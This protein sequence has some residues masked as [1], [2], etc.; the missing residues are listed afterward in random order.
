M[1]KYETPP[2]DF[3]RREQQDGLKLTL[4]T[5]RAKYKFVFIHHLGGGETKDGLRQFALN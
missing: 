5:S 4:E 2:S 3:A 1:I